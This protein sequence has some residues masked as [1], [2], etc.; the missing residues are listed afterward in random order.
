MCKQL[1]ILLNYESTCVQNKYLPWVF[2]IITCRI[3]IKRSFHVYN[4]ISE[5]KFANMYLYYVT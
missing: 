5:D 1:N 4:D 3:F 2:V